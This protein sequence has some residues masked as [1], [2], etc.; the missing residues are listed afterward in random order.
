[1][2]KITSVDVAKNSAKLWKR[3]YYSKGAWYDPIDSNAKKIYE[4]LKTAKTWEEVDEIAGNTSWSTVVCE[5]CGEE[6]RTA[7]VLG[8][9]RFC[10][11]CIKNAYSLL[12]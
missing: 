4:E 9:K 2:Y 10:L 1:M 12:R 6:V 3:Q 11:E 8:K 5:E 7:V